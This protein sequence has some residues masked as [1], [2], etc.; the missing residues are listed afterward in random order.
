MEK[1]EG[2]EEGGVGGRFEGADR[3]HGTMQVEIRGAGQGVRG[4]N[5]EKD[6]GG[7]EDWEIERGG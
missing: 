3:F 7:R 1:V 5:H 2:K 4:G 6:K